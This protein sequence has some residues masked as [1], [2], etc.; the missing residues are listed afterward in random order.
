MCVDARICVW[1]DA[2]K[3]CCCSGHLSSLTC[4]VTIVCDVGATQERC[5]A[6]YELALNQY[7]NGRFEEAVLTFS[8]ALSLV[9]ELK[10]SNNNLLL[11]NILVGIG[12]TQEARQ[13]HG[14]A[15]ACYHQ[16]DLFLSLSPLPA[17]Y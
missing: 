3:G 2:A 12:N 11:A 7:D 15:L 9:R 13:I 5:Q 1:D 16:V 14:Q 6:Q 8:Q 4:G 10:G 17:I